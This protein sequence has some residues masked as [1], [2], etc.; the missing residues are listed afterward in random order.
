MK[1]V[2][3]IGQNHF[4]DVTTDELSAEYL[5]EKKGE[6]VI[7]IRK[8]DKSENCD[9]PA[10]VDAIETTTIKEASLNIINLSHDD[11]KHHIIDLTKEECMVSTARVV[12]RK[13][14]MRWRSK[15][16]ALENIDKDLEHFGDMDFAL[17][18]RKRF[19]DS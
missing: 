8:N 9:E 5:V 3:L 10:K 17:F 7:V 12:H 19:K 16:L 11:S 2:Q 13:T 14:V 4:I 18:M 1:E 15:L 6:H